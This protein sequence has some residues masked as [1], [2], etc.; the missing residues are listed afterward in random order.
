MAFLQPRARRWRVAGAAVVV[1]VLVELFQL[2]S[3]PAE[4]S[5][6]WSPLRLVF[7]T[8]FNPWDLPAYLVGAAGA[9]TSDRLLGRVPDRRNRERVRA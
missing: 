2:T 4:W 6:A 5:S 7:G 3:Y 9:C 8:T 1:C